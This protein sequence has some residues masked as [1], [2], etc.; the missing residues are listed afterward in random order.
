LNQILYGPS[1]DLVAR[2]RY[3]DV[4]KELRKDAR[5]GASMILSLTRD[6]FLGDDGQI[7]GERVEDFK[8]LALGFL[9]Q[10]Y[11]SALISA[12]IHMDERT[13]HNP[14]C[15]ARIRCHEYLTFIFFVL[16]LILYLSLMVDY[17]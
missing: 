13:P 17:S 10:K 7:S 3:R 4:D 12:V 9:R 16:F 15:K 8:T 5:R 6:A 1:S 2:A 11:E 14:S